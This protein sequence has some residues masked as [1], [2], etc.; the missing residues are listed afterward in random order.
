MDFKAARRRMVDSQVRAND[1]TDLRLQTAL[2]TTPREAFLPAGLRDQ[3][4]VERELEYAPGRTL[5]TARDF[6]KLAEAAEPEKG[7]LCLN[8]AVGAGYAAAVLARLVDMVV[9]V[10]SDETL[11][12]AAQENLTAQGVSNAAVLC[13]DSARGAADQGPFDLIFI[14]GVIEKRPDA[15]FEQLKD[16]GRLAAI[17]RK[18]GVSRGVLYTRAG[19]AVGSTPVFDATAKAVLPGFEAEK[20]FVF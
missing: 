5:M 19:E 7:D 15:L 10:E 2:E 20:T 12:A 8:V 17:M 4:Y 9:A 16:G 11:A 18:D 6:A 1:V 14:D 3:A 13:Q